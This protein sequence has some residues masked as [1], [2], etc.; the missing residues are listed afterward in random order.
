[1]WSTSNDHHP[2]IPATTCMFN[3][4]I[5]LR[6][7]CLFVSFDHSVLAK[8]PSR[9][10]PSKSATSAQGCRKGP[11]TTLGA[12]LRGFHMPREKQKLKMLQWWGCKEMLVAQKKEAL[13]PYL[14]KLSP[15][16]QFFAGSI[17]LQAQWS[18]NILRWKLTSC[19]KV[20][21]EDVFPTE[22]V[23]FRGR[24]RLFRVCSCCHICA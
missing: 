1:M 17:L 24:N 20:R 11:G 6:N 23:P 3:V 14:Y 2:A 9:F 7:N 12:E 18:K 13:G 21:L 15:K 16:G 19:L 5:C 8:F 4:L 22:I 10:H